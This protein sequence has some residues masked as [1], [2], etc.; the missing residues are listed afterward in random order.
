MVQKSLASTN[1][2]CHNLT[3]LSPHSVVGNNSC[4]KGNDFCLLIK[5]IAPLYNFSKQSDVY[6]FKKKT[7]INLE[8]NYVE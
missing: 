1:P 6:L 5:K 7:S 2:C 3:A 4:I 8:K